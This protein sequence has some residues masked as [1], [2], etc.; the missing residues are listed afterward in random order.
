L[1]SISFFSSFASNLLYL[2]GDPQRQNIPPSLDV[3]DF[4]EGQG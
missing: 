2:F 3:K 1:S 4:K